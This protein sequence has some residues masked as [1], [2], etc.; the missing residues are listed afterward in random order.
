MQKLLDVN[1]MTKILGIAIAIVILFMAGTL[2]FTLPVMESKLIG[3][4]M[5]Q[6]RDM[7]ETVHRLVTEYQARVQKGEF[8]LEEAQRRAKERILH[9]RYGQGDYFWIN[10]TALPYPTMIMHPTSPALD[11]KVLDNEKF[12]K[13]TQVLA[14]TDT[15]ARQDVERKNLFQA[16]VEVCRKAGEGFVTYQWPKPLKEGGVTKELFTKESYV[17]LFE[18]WGWIIGTGV[19][20]D[21]I[22]AEIGHIRNQLLLMSLAVT[23]VS[24]LLTYAL[25]STI[26]KPANALVAYAAE[27]EK[28]NYDAR[29]SGVFSG[30]LK[31]L[32]ASVQLMVAALK[33]KIAQA[34]EH[35]RQAGLEAE[36]ARVATQQAEQAKLQAERARQ[37]GMLA[38]ADRIEDI[39]AILSTASDELSAQI[40]ESSKGAAVQSRHIAETATAMEEMNATVIEVAKNAGQAAETSDG[41]RNQAQDG[42]RVVENVVKGI[43]SV[44]TQA[45]ALKQDMA[46]LGAQAEGIG[47]I[48]GVISDI[49]DQT[50]LLALNAAIEAARA[51]EAGRGFAVV[52]DEVRKLAEKTMTATKEVGDAIR[53]I[54]QGTRKNVDNVD[55]AVRTIEETTTQ[56]ARSGEALAEIVHLVESSTDQ[57]R[58]IATASEQQSAASDQISRAISTINAIAQQSADGM[59]QAAQ[60]VSQ[61]AEQAQALKRLVDELK[62]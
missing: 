5:K 22:Q 12:N 4:R 57:V 50:N 8:P 24:L 20:V 11:G 55:R 51:G 38:A 47:R 53:D 27:V 2:F 42:A 32:K 23:L 25:A 10:D 40:D 3:S 43:A 33:E 18:P 52:A 34:D 44:Q 62:G 48:M 49:A 1:V 7:T 45:L 30:E 39:V 6:M 58:S 36:N 21:D 60:A 9:M 56:A 19:Y 31:H 15:G 46:E 41:A 59:D 26:S 17:R 37:E 16:T 35:S 13:A 61:L 29:I 14:G 54:Q 28:G